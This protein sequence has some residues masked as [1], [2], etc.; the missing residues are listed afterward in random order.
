MGDGDGP[1]M[2]ADVRL[3]AVLRAPAAATPAP[4]AVL[5]YEEPAG[6][7]RS[8]VF[9]TLRPGD[10][11]LAFAGSLAREYPIEVLSG[12]LASLRRDV[13]ALRDAASRMDETALRLHGIDARAREAQVRLYDAAL[14]ALR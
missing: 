6:E 12:P 9:Y 5:R 3:D 1:R 4:A 7:P 2:E 8:G 10:R 11:V 13:T 14:A